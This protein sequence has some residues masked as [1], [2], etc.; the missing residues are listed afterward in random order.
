MRRYEAQV[1]GFQCIPTAVEDGLTCY[2]D[3]AILVATIAAVSDILASPVSYL[4]LGRFGHTLEES[5]ET[6]FTR[7]TERSCSSCIKLGVRSLSVAYR[8][9]VRVGT[10]SSDCE[11]TDMTEGIRYLPITAETA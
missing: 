1:E 11:S 10:T 7:S 8:Y 5:L 2:D 3:N 6:I 9:V 4:F